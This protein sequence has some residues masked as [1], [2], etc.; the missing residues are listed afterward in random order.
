[1]IKAFLF[2]IGNVLVR[3][4]YG[5]VFRVVEQVIG[6]ERVAEVER[7]IRA[8]GQEMECGVVSADEFVARSVALIGPGMGEMEFRAVFNDIF[9]VNEPMLTVVERL[10]GRVPLYLFSNTS[11]L[12]ER[13]L[14]ERYEVFGRFQ[15]GFYSWSAGC[16]KPD[17]AFYRKALDVLGLEPGEIAY[18]DD[19]PDNIATGRR[20]GLVS[21]AYDPERHE[22]LEEFLAGL[23]LG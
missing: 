2:D 23:E 22:D 7:E 10:R 8:L 3:F 4:D 20:L 17:E 18:I 9:W 13:Y 19:L 6:A 16:M 14:F 21:H 1:M 12:H 11:E 15:G 5:R